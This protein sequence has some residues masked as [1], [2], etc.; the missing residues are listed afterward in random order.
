MLEIAKEA[1]LKTQIM[2]KA[3]LSFTQLKNYLDFLLNKGFITQ[4]SR[5][6]SDCNEVYIIT[7]KGVDF[8][9]VHS[10]LVRLLKE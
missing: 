2:Y 1:S 5:S 3:N 4:T 8:L 6:G 7:E 10:E 9:H